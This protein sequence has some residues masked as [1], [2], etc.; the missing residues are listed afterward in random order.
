MTK[1]KTRVRD[2]TYLV[3]DLCQK[4]EFLRGVVALS[5]KDLAL[6]APVQSTQVSFV[7]F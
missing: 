3:S 1:A 7:Q 4:L 6:D 2:C 5:R